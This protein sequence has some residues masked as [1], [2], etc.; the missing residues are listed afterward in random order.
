VT[1]NVDGRLKA[2]LSTMDMGKKPASNALARKLLEDPM[3][4]GFGALKISH[5]GK[6]AGKFKDAVHASPGQL[7]G[8]KKT[9]DRHKGRTGLPVNS[10]LKLPGPGP[11]ETHLR[12]CRRSTFKVTASQQLTRTGQMKWVKDLVHG[13]ARLQES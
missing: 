3:K 1:Q 8:S 4:D 6:H 9:R 7:D 11:M 10:S 12:Q 13:K 5:A 2:S